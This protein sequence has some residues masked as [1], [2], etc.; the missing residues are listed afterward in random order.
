MNR[1]LPL[2]PAVF[3]FGLTAT[4]V[5]ADIRFGPVLAGAGQSVRLVSHTTTLGATVKLEKD[6]RTSNGK[7]QYSRDRDLTWTFRNPAADG[8]LRGM[9]TVA[10]INTY[11]TTTLDGKTEKSDEASPLNGKMFAMSKAVKGDWKFE[12]DGSVPLKEIDSEISELTLYLKRQWYPHRTVKA[13]ESWEFDPAWIRML[14]QRDLKDAQTIG[15]MNLAQIIHSTDGS[16]A[17]IKVSVR[18][19]GSDFRPDGT[20]SAAQI[21]LSGQVVVNLKTMLDESLELKGT[22]ISRT[23]K[24]GET[25]TVTLPVHLEV[26]KT[27]VNN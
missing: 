5:R 7:I 20:E 6:G 21:E 10:K 24:P 12:L 2:L 1:C 23:G 11:A 18:S 13:G 27:L 4:H 16:S 3:A 25:R 19:T 22:V 17:I 8:S 14:I 26:T 15:T 9:V